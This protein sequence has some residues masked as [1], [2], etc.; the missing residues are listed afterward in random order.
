MFQ[1]VIAFIFWYAH[2]RVDFGIVSFLSK[3]TQKCSLVFFS[4]I[5]H[6]FT[7]FQDAQKIIFKFFV[8]F[9]FCLIYQL[10]ARLPFDDQFPAYR[11]LVYLYVLSSV[12]IVAQPIVLCLR[13]KCKKLL[14]TVPLP[15]TCIIFRYV[16]LIIRRLL[17]PLA[18]LTSFHFSF[19]CSHS[20]SFA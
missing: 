5:C 3:I 16:S 20:P 8:N 1:N 6:F 10:V 2:K 14:S 17:A 15:F 13:K 19:F 4:V 12:H 18:F 7:G 11:A 9:S